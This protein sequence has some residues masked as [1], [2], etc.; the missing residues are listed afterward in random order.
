MH[1]V[2][3]R[4]SIPTAVMPFMLYRR[5]RDTKRQAIVTINTSLQ[6]ISTPHATT[7]KYTLNSQ[8]RTHCAIVYTVPVTES[9]TL[10]QLLALVSLANFSTSTQ[11]SADLLE[12]SVE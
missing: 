4:Y 10:T 7:A 3:Q 12:V 1:I 11:V 9:L 2:T 5:S 8:L 6:Q